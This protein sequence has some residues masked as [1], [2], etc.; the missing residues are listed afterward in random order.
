[1][2]ILNSII[3]GSLGSK[4]PTRGT[5]AFITEFSTIFT[6]LAVG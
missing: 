5:M 1:M 2:R 6:I 4:A 3:G